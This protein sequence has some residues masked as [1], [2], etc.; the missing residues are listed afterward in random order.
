MFFFSSRRRHTRFDCDWS[1][2]VCSSDL[3]P[4]DWD[5]AMHGMQYVK[6]CILFGRFHSLAIANQPI[7]LAIAHTSP[8][9]MAPVQ[10][11]GAFSRQ[12]PFAQRL[13]RYP[14]HPARTPASFN[15]ENHE[16]YT[17]PIEFHSI[18]RTIQGAAYHQA[19]LDWNRVV[20]YGDGHRPEC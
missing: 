14:N 7:G 18:E 8:H 17:Q 15:K 20:R 5:L 10:K 16:R 12:Q 19:G 2:D 11:R 13:L 3:N 9:R 6:N 1:S 4:A